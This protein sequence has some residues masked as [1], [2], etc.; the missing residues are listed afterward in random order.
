M[1][2]LIIIIL[3]LF[4]LTSCERQDEITIDTDIPVLEAYLL[5]G[6]GIENIKLTK[7]I[8]YSTED[9]V[10]LETINDA[11]IKIISNNQV[12]NLMQSKI[13]SGYYYYA[14]SS[15]LINE[16]TEYKIEFSYN[17]RLVSASTISPTKPANFKISDSKIYM[18]RIVEGSTPTFSSE[19]YE[20]IWDNPDEKYYYLSIEL[21]ES[22]PDPINYNYDEEPENTLSNLMQIDVYNLTSRA[23]RFFGTYRVVLYKVNQEYVNLYE[24][25]SQTS[26]SITEPI[27]NI[28]NGKGIFTSFNS[29]TLFF[30]V[31]EK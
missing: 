16:D 8:P 15:L 20:I 3:I 19:T 10:V 6:K 9:D 13:E 5:P 4:V 28:E 11:E 2:H 29:D 17:E 14:D 31:I 21:M 7:L 30:K 12:Y 23:I 26:L 1:K 27:T 24:N 18:D 22:N 25:I